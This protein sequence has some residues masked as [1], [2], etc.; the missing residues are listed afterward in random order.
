MDSIQDKQG[1]YL[2]EVNSARGVVYQKHSG[3]FDKDTLK[4]LDADYKQKVL[5][6]LKGKKWAKCCDLT[7]Y[8]VGGEI[9]TEMAIHN[10]DMID[11]GMT[12]AVLIVENP[13]TKLQMNRAGRKSE[14]SPVEVKNNIQAEEYLRSHGF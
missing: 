8:H 13:I 12:E 14:F 6:L 1:K 7:N 9:N 11:A 10:K 2:I 4:R 5:P 3:A